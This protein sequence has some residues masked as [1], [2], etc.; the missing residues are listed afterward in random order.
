MPGVAHTKASEKAA[1]STRS[2]FAHTSLFPTSI[3]DYDESSRYSAFADG[4]VNAQGLHLTRY[5]IRVSVPAARTLGMG[6]GDRFGDFRGC[7]GPFKGREQR[8]EK[9][10]KLQGKRTTKRVSCV[11]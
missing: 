7:S 10:V 2:S 11:A 1:A 8:A 4:R 5:A 3:S 6:F 9:P